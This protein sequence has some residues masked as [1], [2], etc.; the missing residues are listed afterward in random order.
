H[1]DAKDFYDANDEF[2]V[3]NKDLNDYAT[4]QEGL[5]EPDKSVLERALRENPFIYFVDFENKGGLVTPL[6]LTFTFDDGSKK[7]IMI[8]A[9][10][11]RTDNQ[12]VTKMFIETKKVVSIEYDVKH[13]TADAVRANN[14]WP[15]RSEP[16]RLEV[17]RMSPRS[18][19]NQMAEAL[20]EL[21][22]KKA[23][24]D[25]PAAPIAP[26]Q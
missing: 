3:N 13:Q 19:R 21:R 8:P 4:Y 14:N 26:A 12:K 10:I 9:E 20:T 24:P 11:W 1:P 25:S 16:S 6:P 2:V 22:A 15:A 5:K 18:P 17:F 23:E 7:E